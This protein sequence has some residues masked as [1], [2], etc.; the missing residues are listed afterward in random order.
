MSIFSRRAAYLLTRASFPARTFPREASN[1][2]FERNIFKGLAAIGAACTLSSFASSSPSLSSDAAFCHP[3]DLL[4]ALKDW[5]HGDI[6]PEAPT[7]VSDETREI[8]RKSG[9]SAAT[10][11]DVEAAFRALDI[12][13]NDA[14]GPREFARALRFLGLGDGD[15]IGRLFTVADSNRTGMIKFPDFVAFLALLCRPFRAAGTGAGGADAGGREKMRFLFRC[16]DLNGDGKITREELATVLQ[17]LLK[18]ND[19]LIAP[20]A[21][22]SAVLLEKGANTAG[23]ADELYAALGQ[24]LADRAF[25][26]A[27][28][29]GQ[30]EDRMDADTF[31]AWCLSNDVSAIELVSLF[32]RMERA[33]ASMRRRSTR[34]RKS[35]KQR[36]QIIR[37]ESGAL[38]LRRK[39]TAARNIQTAAIR[40]QQEDR[41]A[42]TKL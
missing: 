41:A 40:K 31:A 15:L 23:G 13:E 28:P 4:E 16:C 30:D 21:R 32:S 29:R 6:S 3:R 38:N 27:G 18:M 25:A 10:A 11:D 17:S 36:A 9:L 26:V 19:C 5:W 39:S 2:F 34:T 7:V 20:S 12:N 35:N 1:I 14:L 37:R 33:L 24:K 42:A 22:I 8:V